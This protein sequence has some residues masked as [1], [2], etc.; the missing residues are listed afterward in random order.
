[1]ENGRPRARY[2]QSWSDTEAQ[3]KKLCEVLGVGRMDGIEKIEVTITADG[4]D[5]VV[6]PVRGA[7]VDIAPPGEPA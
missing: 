2:G 6:T 5:M 4:V 7:F 1:M 3:V